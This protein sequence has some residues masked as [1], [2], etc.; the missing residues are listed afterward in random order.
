MDRLQEG[1]TQELIQS[2]ELAG[3][4]WKS[5][6][7]IVALAAGVAVV[8]TCSRILI[9]GNS[10]RAVHDLRELLFDKLLKLAPSFYQRHQTGHLM[11][12]AVNDVQNVQGLMGPV[13]MYL[14][15]TAALYA[16]CLTSM[17]T[18]SPKLTAISLLP[19]PLFL[20]A[21]RSLAGRIHQ[22]SRE[23]QE[24]L[25]QLSAKVDESLSGQ[26]IIKSLTL[27]SFDRDLFIAH[28]T[29]LKDT[30]LKLTW[31]RATLM[32]LM[33]V[34]VSF[35]TFLTLIFGGPMVSGGAL[36]LGDFVALVLYLQMV[37]G[38]TAALGFV[39]S[40]LQR[41]AAAL[42]RIREILETEVTLQD[43]SSS[44]ERPVHSGALEVRELT[45]SYPS[46]SPTHGDPSPAEKRK[47]TV[48]DRISFKAPAGSFIGVV[49]PIGSGK[50]TLI[51][52]LARQLEIGTGQV[53]L[54]NEDLTQLPIRE[55]RK[56]VGLVPQ[57]N[58]LFSRS[59]AENVA[60]GKPEASR[61]AVV[62]A[63]EAS[64]LAQDLPQLPKGLDT[65]LGER[66]VNLSGGQRQR[67]AL[68]RVMLLRPKLL[69][70]DDT[71][72]AVDTQTAEKILTAL[73][74]LMAGR[75]TVMVAHRLR[76][77]QRADLILVL[78]NGRL[79]ETGKHEQLLASGGLYAALYAQQEQRAA[80]KE[81]L[82]RE[83]QP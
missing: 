58:F 63:V 11:S 31:L 45:V 62:Q 64:Q 54:D 46:S 80:L 49:G 20:V 8:R 77:L 15:E 78:E 26:L 59:L 38:P 44:P 69:L 40:S 65:L 50:T 42:A 79:V 71:L 66:G 13:F 76:H 17:L 75:T 41:G 53:F 14:S 61:E 21:A 39:L 33:V 1:E 28:A 73:E 27:E 32:P 70:L 48:L 47:R 81:D 22:S 5:A 10:R 6:L 35:S 67:T 25:G 19:F 52:A 24:R 43:S 7:G 57:D 55:V 23:A 37:A 51:R 16:I 56:A 18:L 68:A 72:S 3:L 30:H 29:E 60:L 4:I 74:P 12:R 83:D 34:L 82:Q 36:S 9:L 2:G